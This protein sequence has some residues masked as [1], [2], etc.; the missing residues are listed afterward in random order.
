MSKSI[1]YSIYLAALVYVIGLVAFF[2]A[3]LA[4]TFAPL[5]SNIQLTGV[6]GTLWQ[7][8]VARLQFG[9]NTLEQLQWQVF[10]LALLSGQIAADVDIARTP[11]NPV[12]GN[13]RV[14]VGLFGGARL[15]NARFNGELATL[16]AWLKIPDLV[17]LRG[18]IILAV[19]E[20]ELGDPVC[21]TLNARVGG[22][23]VKTRIGSQWY[24]LGD[25]ALQLGCSEG[26]ATLLIEPDNSL[27]LSV[28]GRFA[29]SNVD[30]GVVM[31][32]T[33]ATPA[34]IHELL[35]M[36]GEPDSNGQFSF[37]FRL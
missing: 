22:Y 29:P 35:R 3:R 23:E 31:Q 11:T 28:S 1:R 25:F 27:G 20:Y 16:G 19:A 37:R 17:P 7:G 8:E 4:V 32:P 18:E 14:L 21:S 10:P 24:E 15:E 36:V 34:P 33:S 26:W 6:T 13:A 2:P 12:S 5:P 30:F 9:T